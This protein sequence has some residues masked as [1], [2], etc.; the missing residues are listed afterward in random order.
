M[1]SQAQATPPPHAAVMQMVMGAWVSQ[2]ISSVTRL[3][4][5]DLV[6]EHGPLTAQQLTTTH[7]VAVQPDFLERALRACASVGS[8]RKMQTDASGQRRYQRC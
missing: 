5:P 4:I 2:T 1:S 7:G 3:H 6:Q 8:S